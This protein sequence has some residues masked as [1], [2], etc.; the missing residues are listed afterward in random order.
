MIEERF[1]RKV[2]TA[3]LLVA[4]VAIFVGCIF[5]IV[6]F[7]LRPLYN[8]AKDIADGAS[9]NLDDILTIVLAVLIVAGAE[10]AFNTVMRFIWQ[11]RSNRALVYINEANTTLSKAIERY[12]RTVAVSEQTDELITMLEALSEETQ[13]RQADARETLRRA[14]VLMDGA[15]K[16][17]EGTRRIVDAIQSS[18]EKKKADLPIQ[19]ASDTHQRTPGHKHVKIRRREE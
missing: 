14:Q 7:G 8:T 17:T 1:G 4:T 13:S 2:A 5:V 19:Q 10:L 18:L 15:N 16:N 11:S 12:N 9:V 6:T 3:L